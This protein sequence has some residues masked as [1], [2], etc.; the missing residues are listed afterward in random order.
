M[1]SNTEA[2]ADNTG[3]AVAMGVDGMMGMLVGAAGVAGF[4]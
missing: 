4:F 2:P 1:T 3:A